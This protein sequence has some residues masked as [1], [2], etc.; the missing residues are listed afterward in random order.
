MIIYIVLAIVSIKPSLLTFLLE[1]LFLDHAGKSPVNMPSSMVATVVLGKTTGVLSLRIP[2]D[3]AN[4][5]KERPQPRVYV[6]IHLTVE[7]AIEP[8]VFWIRFEHLLNSC[9]RFHPERK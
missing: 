2:G 3:I 4:T 8:V 1:D 5:F 9:H 7:P 6:Q